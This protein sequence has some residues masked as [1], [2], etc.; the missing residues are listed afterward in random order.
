ML[1]LYCVPLHHTASLSLFVDK[2]P[3]GGSFRRPCPSL[4]LSVFFHLPRLLFD[5]SLTFLGLFRFLLPIFCLYFL[6]HLHK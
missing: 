3:H 5:L 2:T 1:A 6:L 4:F